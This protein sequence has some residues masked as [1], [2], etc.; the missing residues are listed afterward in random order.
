MRNWKDSLGLEQRGH[1]KPLHERLR[2]ET[3][4]EKAA[5][6][7]RALAQTAV[8][9]GQGIGITRCIFHNTVMIDYHC[10]DCQQE[11]R[12]GRI[13]NLLAYGL[14][15]YRGEAPTPEERPTPYD[16]GPLRP[17]S[18][19]S[20]CGR[21]ARRRESGTFYCRYEGASFNADGY[22]RGDAATRSKELL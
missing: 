3:L 11:A 17:G 7:R 22:F 18:I 10:T 14:A 16:P 21:K 2:P 19:C 5:N 15:R 9:E 13:E 12:E 8:N 1:S 6:R 4:L 20:L